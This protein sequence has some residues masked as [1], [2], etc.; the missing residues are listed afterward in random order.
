M[1]FS[2]VLLLLV[3]AL[4]SAVPAGASEHVRLWQGLAPDAREDGWSGPGP[5]DARQDTVWFGGDAGNGIAF[6]GGVWDFETPG[7]N[8]FQGCTSSDQTMNPGTYFGVVTAADFQ[9][10]GDPCVPMIQG[11]TGQIW[12]G[13]HQDEADR[14]DF[15]AGMGYQD[16]MC[17]RAFSPVRV[18]NP[19]SQ[20]VDIAFTY[21]VHSEWSFDYTY[22]N[23]LCYDNTNELIDEHRIASLCGVIG[24][25]QDPSIF[26]EGIEVPAGSLD[27]LT[28]SVQLEFRMDADG[29]ASDEDG[30]WDSPCGPFAADNISIAVGGST[31]TYNF[32][33][34][35]QGWTFERCEGAG[36]YMHVVHDYEYEDWL[37][38]LGLTCNCPLAGNAVAFVGTTC[39][40]GPGLVPGQYEQFETGTVVRTGYPA[41][42]WNDVIVRF[43]AFLNLPNSTGGAY[44]PGF[45]YYPYTTEV[46][47]APH[48]SPRLGQN[49]WLGTSSPFCARRVFDLTQMADQSL[50]VD[51]DSLKFVCEVT[52]DCDAFGFPPSVCTEE[53]CTGGAPV[54][55]AI[56]VGLSN[57]ADAPPISLV[58]GGL[59]HDGFGQN[60][61]TF[62]EP[63]D[64]CNANISYDLSREDTNQN[65]WNGDSSVVTG[66]A[67]G[68]QAT[69]WLCELCFKVAEAGARQQMI[70]DYHEWKARLDG[71][72]EEDFV[73]VLMDSLQTNNNTQVWKNKFATYF[74][75]DDPGYRGPG[76]YNA[77]NEILPDQVFVPGTRIEY[78]WRSFWF[79][80][81]APPE[82]YYL[83]GANP[84]REFELL[85]GMEVRPGE[86][87]TVQW[88]SVLYVDAFNGNAEPYLLPVLEQLTLP[89]DKFDYLDTSS[90]WNSSMKRD[91][92]GTVHNPGGYGNNGCTAQQ[93][94][95][96]R[97]IILNSGSF[98]VNT[99]EPEDFDMFDQWLTTTDCGLS[100]IRRGFI[101]DGDQI[102]EIMADEVHG[103]AI[104]FAHNVLGVTLVAQSYRDHNTDP[105]FCVLLE[106][107]D[108]PLF[109]PAE[110]G[111]GLWGNG[112]PQ[113]FNYNVLGIQP[114][115]S[116]VVGNLD[117]WSHEQTGNQ[118]YV[119]FAQVVR[120]NEQ[121]GIANWRTIVNGFSFHHL[122][123]RSCQGQACSNDSTCRVHG[124]ADLF[125]PMIE[126]IATGGYPFQKW[127]YPCFNT[128]V[129]PDPTHVSGPVNY[130]YQS[131]PN[132][133]SSRATIRFSL[134]SAGEVTLMVVDVAGRRV[135]T[136][137]NAAA[138]A[139]ENTVVWDGT[140]NQ[141][142]PVGAGVFWMQMTTHDGYSSGRKMLVLR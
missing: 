124:T 123:E 136:L 56:V 65:D 47:P 88:P 10:H 71:D 86:T 140:D 32:D 14:R 37:D 139:G 25:H 83:L 66:P 64:R 27:P 117:F 119:E 87:Y 55:D 118:E 24:D 34:G 23:L 28:A 126:W 3:L 49:S 7:S 91:M 50:P 80:G 4:A 60:Y 121:A 127:N 76:D 100:E 9:T 115:V 72:P 17:Q 21:F 137:L 94:M 69:R 114:G 113:E 129:D 77:V 48:W 90:N 102:A 108:N 82:E 40:N 67:V 122:S 85:P 133:F 103:Y 92:G 104:N 52:A 81:G 42:Y 106:P 15:L 35:A 33:S 97:L 45:R 135:K 111:V 120:R 61:P 132:P 74:H 57:I 128:G 99:M 105:A 68:S 51:W 41:P 6:V 131:R 5:G 43:N 30:Q 20:S 110:P 101:F 59:F 26:D 11:T 84:V 89:Y 141:G 31:Q 70:P 62:L 116:N 19:A 13:I 22:V 134:A 46:N 53:G 75:E 1:R 29:A 54:F 39:Q 58:D 138:P 78:Y 96:Y 18:I 130:L 73:C 107:V 125:G 63:S 12:C 8:G 38:D 16:D 98:G 36:A 79:N 112:C 2:W 109:S 95:G 93:L 44:R 142:K